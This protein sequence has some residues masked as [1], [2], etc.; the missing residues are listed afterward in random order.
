ML[1]GEESGTADRPGESGRLIMARELG[2]RIMSLFGGEE[3]RNKR[4]EW[5]HKKQISDAEW[6]DAEFTGEQ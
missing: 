3:K 1:V 4:I 2:S 5:N 6:S